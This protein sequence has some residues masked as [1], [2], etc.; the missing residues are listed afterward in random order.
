MKLKHKTY[1]GIKKRH[2]KSNKSRIMMTIQ[3]KGN[4]YHHWHC[5][6]FFGEFD[7]TIHVIF[8]NINGCEAV[9]HY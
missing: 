8:T 7:S 5:V 3:G 9:R 2:N 6:K 4:Y 1:S